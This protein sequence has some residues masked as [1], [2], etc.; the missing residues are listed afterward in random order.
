MKKLIVVLLFS[1]IQIIG[2]NAQSLFDGG[3]F[4]P[5]FS[6]GAGI[7]K[8]I[9]FIPIQTLLLVFGN[10]VSL[11]YGFNSRR[12]SKNKFAPEL[13]SGLRSE[14]M[15]FNLTNNFDLGVRH[16]WNA[17]LGFQIIDKKENPFKCRIGVIHMYKAT[18]GFAEG[19]LQK[20]RLAVTLQIAN[21]FGHEDDSLYPYASIGFLYQ[22]KGI[23]RK[24]TKNIL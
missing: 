3:S 18:G 5:T 20:D 14:R 16:G 4:G 11:R 6:G 21:L 12:D 13:M 10:E 15:S 17:R 2:L 1:T 8:N 19:M 22:Y 23:G 9:I 24:N 7:D